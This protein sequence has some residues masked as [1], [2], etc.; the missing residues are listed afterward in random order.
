L[1]RGQHLR[2]AVTARPFSPPDAAGPHQFQPT[3]PGAGPAREA[4][5]RFIA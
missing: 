5:R 3:P 2:G 1:R 4:A